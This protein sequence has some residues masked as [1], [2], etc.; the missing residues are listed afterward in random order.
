MGKK[1]VHFEDS[2]SANVIESDKKKKKKDKKEKKAHSEFAV[3]EKK[4]KKRSRDDASQT[5]V[6]TDEPSLPLKKAKKSK[7]SKIS[8]VDQDTSPITGRPYSDKALEILETRK[9]L[10]C[11][12]KKSAFLELVANNQVTIL[13]GETGSGKTTQCPQFLAE[14]YGPTSS[15]NNTAGK[16]GICQPRRVAA[17]SVASRVAEEM[18]VELGEECGYLIR[19]EDKT[20]DKTCVKYMTDGMLLREAMTDPE[21]SAYSVIC[22]DEAH[23]RT[24][25]TDILFGLLK[26]LLVKRK[27]LKLV[28]MSATLQS[29]K[30][31]KFF[32]G[33]PL[34]TISG[35]MYPVEV[36]HTQTAEKDYVGSAID[37][38]LGICSGRDLGYKSG[39]KF[40]GLRGLNT[41]E[42]GNAEEL[43]QPNTNIA[44]DILIFLTGEEEIEN[45]CRALEDDVDSES[46]VV[47]PLYSS[48]PP[49]QQRLV[50]ERFYNKETGV[51]KRKIVVATNVAET[52]ITLDGVVFVI[53]CGL[54]KSKSYNPRTQVES[55]LVQ[56]ISKAAAKQRAGRAGRTK[57]GQC[58]RLY[59]QTAFETSLKEASEPEILRT[60]LADAVLTLLKVGQKNVVKFP[61]LDS[62]A[63]ESMMRALQ[64]LLHLGAVTSDDCS[65][66]DYGRKLADLPLEPQ[67]GAALLAAAELGV[68]EQM[69]AVVGLVSGVPCQMRPRKF[70]KQ[71]DRAHKKFE[72]HEG[73]HVTLLNIFNAFL[74]VREGRRIGPTNKK[75]SKSAALNDNDFG[76]ENADEEGNPLP[77]TGQKAAK[78]WAYD[79][80]LKDR[81]L[82]SALSVQ[83]QL[84]RMLSTKLD[85]PISSTPVNKD[86]TE[87]IA[88]RKAIIRGF[89]LQAAH[90]VMGGSGNKGSYLTARERMAVEIHPSSS[91]DHKPEWVVFQELSLTDK[92]Y[93]RTASAVRPE[94][95]LEMVPDFFPS[96]VATEE[97]RKG[98]ERKLKLMKKS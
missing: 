35:R 56:P 95:L 63:P 94:W 29:E 68:A 36:F 18:D 71:A 52:A 12:K 96:Q 7:K 60:N 11:W 65:L 10:P 38:A 75:S 91:L 79:N 39:G 4:K 20:S 26:G 69:A 64:L 53:D 80:Y 90:V 40:S 87:K 19:F 98:L 23:E 92:S 17:M 72:A 21:L 22:L 27:D 85:V 81:S 66:T 45:C 25:S 55:L 57:A 34:I 33:A 37:T 3:E 51:M 50:F 86:D 31:C 46:V 88:V 41:K 2:A 97:A 93:L 77:R 70:A 89:F 78:A 67:L 24:L 44:G 76:Y 84:L 42:T 30:F 54:V 15:N 83:K 62:P 13:V 58:F 5:T 32:S 6:T 59:T 9:K 8:E 47:L 74:E 28:V 48:L 82:E 43:T 16:I 14:V 73:D 1:S 61:W 49:Q